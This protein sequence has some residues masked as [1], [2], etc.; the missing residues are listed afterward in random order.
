MSDKQLASCPTDNQLRAY[1][2][3]V[4]NEEADGIIADHLAGCPKCESKV[5]SLESNPIGLSAQLKEPATTDPLA[6]G[7]ESKAILNAVRQQVLGPQAN[8]APA[9]KPPATA[10]ES[11]KP[12]A[13]P[14]AP[15]SPN[16]PSPKPAPAKPKSSGWGTKALVAAGVLGA[17]AFAASFFNR[18]EVPNPTPSPVD[19]NTPAVTENTETPDGQITPGL[20]VG[21]LAPSTVIESVRVTLEV[22]DEGDQLAEAVDLHFGIGFPL[23]LYPLGTHL[24]SP[25]VAAFPQTSSLTD[26]NTI[27]EPGETVTFQFDANP[28]EDGLDELKNNAALFDGLQVGDIR[29]IGFASIG[30]TDW[31]LRG[32]RIDINGELFAA[33]GNVDVNVGESHAADRIQLEELLPKLQELESDVE[34]LQTYVSLGGVGGDD[35]LSLLDK[36]TELAEYSKPMIELAGRLAGTHNWFLEDSSKLIPGAGVSSPIAKFVVK[37]MSTTAPDAGTHNALYLRLGNRKFPVTSVSQPLNSN[38]LIQEFEVQPQLGPLEGELNAMG[39][40]MIASDDNFDVTPD[41]AQLQRVILEVAGDVIYDS[42]TSTVDRKNLEEFRLIPP[43]HRDDLGRVIVNTP[44]DREVVLWRPGMEVATADIGASE[45]PGSATEDVTKPKLTPEPPAP[46]NELNSGDTPTLAGL[47]GLPASKPLRPVVAVGGLPGLGVSGPPP[48][49]PGAPRPVTALVPPRTTPLERLLSQLI[50]GLLQ[51]QQLARAAGGRSGT[52]GGRSTT[53]SAASVTATKG[54]PVISNVRFRAANG[55]V[56]DTRPVTVTWN[57]SGTTTAVSHYEVT[58]NPIIPHQSRSFVSTPVGQVS[59]A[60]TTQATVTPNITP[61]TSVI[62]TPATLGQLW[63]QPLVRAKDASGNTLGVA[64]TGPILPLATRKLTPA[65]QIRLVPGPVVVPPG[66]TGTIP[67][68]QNNSGTGFN[69][70]WI[71][72][73]NVSASAGGTA[74]FQLTNVQNSHNGLR[75]DAFGA[76]TPPFQLAHNVAINPANSGEF[77]CVRYDARNVIMTQNMQLLANVG[78]INGQS[79]PA[80]AVVGVVVIVSSPVL[81]PHLLQSTPNDGNL[82][83]MRISSNGP[84]TFRKLTGTGSP[85]PQ[86][87]IRVPINFNTPGTTYNATLAPNYNLTFMTPATGVPS[88]PAIPMNVT[89]L[90]FVRLRNGLLANPAT[91]PLNNESVGLFGV[92]IVP[93]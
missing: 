10:G 15:A 21:S 51:R 82:E 33:H 12:S 48:I 39:L 74:A 62:T 35:E 68:F 24:R 25:T 87:L 67:G 93:Q 75:M 65:N 34:T 89:A 26:G 49:V 71:P 86:G 27:V 54:N 41:R 57:V 64:Q 19:E 53:T 16:P 1:V 32:Y 13:K 38:P 52:T 8:G 45:S 61:L 2:D 20:T 55:I 11:S 88:A 43:A 90:F 6:D 44:N 9:A 81:T 83:W 80:R 29:Q 72:F 70:P 56:V 50:R 7:P 73:R 30:E 59:R 85:A 42:E 17:L 79:A 3:G 5:Q 23:R 66:A 37:L 18:P 31:V 40:G 63:V 78:F 58:L 22:G 92:R 36:K 91:A 69:G 28:E 60:T 46:S 14:A 4:L 84:L 77:V 76:T 47:S